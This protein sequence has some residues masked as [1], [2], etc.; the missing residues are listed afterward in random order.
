M[1]GIQKEKCTSVYK[2]YAISFHIHIHYT[3]INKTSTKDKQ[4][5]MDFDF[6]FVTSIINFR[7]KNN[8]KWHFKSVRT[9]KKKIRT[10]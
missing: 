2:K 10:Q 5:T 8:T 3:D 6:S 4:P 7:A 9:H 1:F